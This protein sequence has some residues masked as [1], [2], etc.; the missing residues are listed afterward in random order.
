MARMEMNITGISATIMTDTPPLVSSEFDITSSGLST[1]GA[2]M[3]ENLTATNSTDA[4]LPAVWSWIPFTW[5]WWEVIQLILAIA[6]IIGNSL[7]M[8]VLFRVKR[9][10]CSTDTL[11]AGLALAD[12]LTSVFI[13]PHAQV[14]TLPDTIAAQL[15]CRIIHSSSLMWTSICASIFTLTTISIERLMAVRYPF[16]FQHFFTSRS[17]SL[18]IGGIWLISL[19]INTVSF[20]VHYIV[21]GECAFGFS[22]PSFQKFIGVF[23]FIAEYLVPVSVMIL[24]HVFTIRTLRERAQVKPYSAE[25]QSQRPNKH[26][27]RARRRVIEMLFIVVV[28][29]IICWTP[30]QFGFLAFTVGIIDFSH[31][32]SPVYRSFVVL[33]FVNSCANPIIYAARN[34]NFRQAL[35]E[36][37]R[38]V[39]SIRLQS[40]FA[41]ID[42]TSNV[43]TD[44][45]ASK[46][47]SVDKV[48]V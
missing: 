44:T 20:Y 16:Q 36:L 13:I 31:F 21:D 24:A 42:E 43:S 18:V 28:I 5:H 19:V 9:K 15:Y 3:S 11:I 34:P 10:L 1:F 26:F 46:L 22:T 8:L 23:Y 12:F 41:A 4:V 2:N 37:F 33:A 29:F 30:D 14:K 25:N 32:N 40:V 38:N 7:V 39:P 35:K 27:L 6:G 47:Y 17:T 48:V 45:S